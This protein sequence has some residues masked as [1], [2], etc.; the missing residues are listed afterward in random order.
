VDGPYRSDEPPDGAKLFAAVRANKWDKTTFMLRG[1]PK[2][3]ITVDLY[4]NYGSHWPLFALL[5]SA[6]QIGCF[7]YW[8]VAVDGVGSLGA[9]TPVG[10]PTWSWL[11]I[12][13]SFPKCGDLSAELWRFFSYQFV[14][15]GLSHLG[16]NM[17]TQLVFGLPLNMVSGGFPNINYFSVFVYF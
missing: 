16:F 4:G 5:V 9:N 8:V 11:R 13:S 10:G 3:Q 1:V 6:V 2:A 7:V 17:V 14:H 15:A 12:V